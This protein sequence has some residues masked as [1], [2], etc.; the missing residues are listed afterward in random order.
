MAIWIC[1][2][3]PMEAAANRASDAIR[4]IIFFIWVLFLWCEPG[5]WLVGSPACASSGFITWRSPFRGS[6]SLQAGTA[7]SCAPDGSV[8]GDGEDQDDADEH[9]LNLE[10]HE[11]QR[12]AV[13]D[14]A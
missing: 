12:E 13:A 1:C 5:M 2:A 11:G 6:T 7:R 14:H 8:H 3:A 10:R 4:A 9:G